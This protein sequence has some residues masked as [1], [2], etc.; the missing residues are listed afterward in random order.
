[1][2]GHKKGI[3]HEKWPVYD[4]AKAASEKV[5]I[6]VQ[7]GGKLRDKLE[8]MPDATEDEIKNEALKSPKVFSHIDGKQVRK[9]IYVPGK[10]VNIVV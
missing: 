9:V 8:V 4:K 6:I 10:L 1:M 2:L 5:T 7:V 3:V